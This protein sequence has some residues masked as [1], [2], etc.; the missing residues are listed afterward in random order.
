MASTHLS[1]R[2]LIS[3]LTVVSVTVA[4]FGCSTASAQRET[5]TVVVAPL[6]GEAGADGGRIS[7][8]ELEDQLRRYADRFYTRV[9]LAT[10][11]IATDAATAAERLL[12]HNWKSVS[13]ATIVELAIGPNAVT[14][15]LDMMVL[16]TLT[17]QTV[18]SYWV[19]EIFGEKGQ[20][21]LDSYLVLEDDIWSIA[22]RV[23]TPAQ[24]DDLT[25]LL[26]E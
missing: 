19:P 2:R 6:A 11:T 8:G 13:V 14:N 1:W 26:T 23:L 20:P 12:M 4:L 7:Q 16:T 9:V 18:E 10:H 22:D 15:L 25:S 5:D 24:Q 21:L 3:S 17:R